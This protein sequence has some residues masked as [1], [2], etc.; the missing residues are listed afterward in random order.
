MQSSS[1]PIELTPEQIQQQLTE[2]K[3][4]LVK[5]EEQLEKE[6]YDALP[7]HCCPILKTIMQDPVITPSGITY[8]RSAL[9]PRSSQTSIVDPISKKS[10]SLH[11]L[12]PNRALLDSINGSHPVVGEIASIKD[13]IKNLQK[14]LENILR[15]AAEVKASATDISEEKKPEPNTAHAPASN[16]A[17]NNPNHFGTYA[18]MPPEFLNAAPRSQIQPTATTLTAPSLPLQSLAAPPRRNP[19]GCDRWFKLLLVGD[20]ACDK[21]ALLLRFCDDSFTTS[22]ITTIGIDF[23]IKTI[24]M[25]NQ[26][27]KLQIWDTAGQERFRTITTA[28]YRGAQGIMLVYDITDQESFQNIHN[29]HRNIR[30]HASSDVSLVLVGARREE[31]QARVVSTAEG[32]ALANELGIPFF[33]CSAR[34]NTNVTEAFIALTRSVLVAFPQANSDQNNRST[35]TTTS[36]SK[37][38]IM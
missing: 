35:E 3:S 28:Y 26:R 9:L 27:I 18:T 32:Q 38:L 10:F 11:Q 13:Q 30:Q 16:T 36:D 2:L 15:S 7:A 22:F 31:E 17:L 24:E 5:K 23:K 8:E 12:V 6:G 29:W 14:K 19:N 21:S 20:S 34:N 1:T 33:E 25:D 4:K 37:C